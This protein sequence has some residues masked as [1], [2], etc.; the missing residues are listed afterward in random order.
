MFAVV[1]IGTAVVL[2]LSALLGKGGT[3]EKQFEQGKE[4][5]SLLLGV[6]GTIIGFYFGSHV[7]VSARRELELSTVD[8]SPRSVE[9]GTKVTIRAVA[10]GGVP[11]YRFNVGL[12]T[13]AVKVLEPVGESG[14]I[15]K[16]VSH[17]AVSPERTAGGPRGSS[18]RK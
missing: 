8:V 15:V 7:A 16:E 14:W 18:R 11:P 5:L 2:V 12:G 3:N 4:I 6:F 17:A 13:D 10:S 1:T 9:A